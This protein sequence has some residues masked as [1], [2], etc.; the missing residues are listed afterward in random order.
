[1]QIDAA[2]KLIRSQLQ[3]MAAA[4]GEPVFDEWVLVGL[5]AAGAGILGYEGPREADYQ[6][7][8]VKDVAPLR[9]VIGRSAQDVGGFEFVNDADGHRYDAVMRA[10]AG[11][12]LLCNHTTLSLADIRANPNWLKAQVAWF[13]LGEKFRADPAVV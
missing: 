9:A 1:M 5:T 6:K 10:G 4:Y 8:F 7:T 3:R 11:V 12:Y 2:S 13:E